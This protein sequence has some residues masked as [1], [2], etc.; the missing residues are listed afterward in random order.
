MENI[1]MKGIDVSRYQGV[2]DWKSVADSGVNFAMIQTG[3]GDILNNP[4]QIDPQ[5]RRNA[6]EAVRAGVAAGAYHFSYAKDEA[7]AVQEARG[8]LELL[9]GYTFTMPI[10]YD[11]EYDSERVTGNL[12]VD[13]LTN[14][15]AAFLSTVENAGYY[16]MLYANLDFIQNRL[17]MDRLSQYDLWYA[18]PGVSELDRAGVGIWQYGQG[19]INGIGSATDLDYAF[20]DYPAVIRSAGLN[21]LNDSQPDPN[22]T[23]SPEGTYT[24][25]SGDTLS[26]IAAAHGVSYQALIAANPQIENPNLIYPGQVLTIPGKDGA[27]GD[28]SS[29]SVTTPGVR[30]RTEP[31]D[32]AILG[33]LYPGET[34]QILYESNGWMK[35]NRA[36]VVGWVSASYVKRI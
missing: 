3:Y 26:A 5:F 27:A 12:S 6:V 21:H 4:N 31:V 20:H 32:G 16:V 1:K 23:P 25:R 17:D 13:Q 33:L 10:A 30:L 9:K 11:F 19:Q 36:G 14:V 22:P 29:G 8:V 2:I 35:V 28:S 24:V 15:L 7:A 18:R 34:F